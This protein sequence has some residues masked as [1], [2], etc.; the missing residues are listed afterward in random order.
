MMTKTEIDDRL[1][2]YRSALSGYLNEA[3]H[4]GEASVVLAYQ[5]QAEAARAALLAAFDALTAAVAES[6]GRRIDALTAAIVADAALVRMEKRLDAVERERDALRAA[7]EAARMTLRHLG[8]GSVLFFETSKHS[9]AIDHILMNLDLAIGK[10]EGNPAYA[11]T[12]DALAE[13]LERERDHWRSNEWRLASWD[14]GV[15]DDPYLVAEFRDGTRDRLSVTDFPDYVEYMEFEGPDDLPASWN[16][17]MDESC[18]DAQAA[19][20][21]PNGDGWRWGA[22]GSPCRWRPFSEWQAFKDEITRAGLPSAW[23]YQTD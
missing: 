14:W 5:E 15:N 6:E 2:E 11:E 3:W 1:D 22:A 13:N 7:A 8:A 21:D 4:N 17:L 16:K 19:L 23:K 10:S 18:A 20:G 12:A 9:G